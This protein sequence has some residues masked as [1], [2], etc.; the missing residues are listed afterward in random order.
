MKAAAEGRNRVDAAGTKARTGTEEEGEPHASR[1]SPVTVAA[2]D[3]SV[4]TAVTS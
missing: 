2:R 4:T 3:Q 1:L